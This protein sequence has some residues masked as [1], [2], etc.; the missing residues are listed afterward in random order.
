M[1]RI[2]VKVVGELREEVKI[3]IALDKEVIYD[4]GRVRTLLS[5]E[6]SSIKST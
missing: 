5:Y 2:E 1:Y 3:R 4:E 6:I